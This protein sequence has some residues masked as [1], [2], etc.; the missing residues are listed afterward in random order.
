MRLPRH[1]A[2][3]GVTTNHVASEV[4]H[5]LTLVRNRSMLVTGMAWANEH[6]MSP[7]GRRLLWRR[8][9]EPGFRGSPARW[10]T[11]PFLRGE[12]LLRVRK[13]GPS[14]RLGEHRKRLVGQFELAQLTWV[15]FNDVSRVLVQ[16]SVL[17]IVYEVV[18]VTCSFGALNCPYIVRG[19]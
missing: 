4:G 12:E 13:G 15:E 9:R 14:R 3:N 16:N 19:T 1:A 5:P 2:G 6:E 10:M 17:Y 7:C 18:D 11:A 8:E